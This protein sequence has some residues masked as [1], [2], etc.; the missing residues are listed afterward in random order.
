LPD[1]YDDQARRTG[2]KLFVYAHPASFDATAAV[3]LEQGARLSGR[4]VFGRWR[5]AME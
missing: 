5:V 2:A 3:T 4:S 1:L